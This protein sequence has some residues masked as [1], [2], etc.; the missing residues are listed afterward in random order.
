MVNQWPS[1]AQPMASQWPTNGQPM[2]SQWPTNGQ[3]MANQWP[4]SHWQPMA[5]QWPTNGQPVAIQWP[6]NVSYF[7]LL[8]LFFSNQLST[9]P[10]SRPPNVC[11]P[12]MRLQPTTV[13]ATQ[14]QATKAAKADQLINVHLDAAVENGG[15]PS[16]TAK[17]LISAT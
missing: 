10:M 15:Q 13:D 3:P 1:N 8:A 2:A 9:R 7:W 14:V 4:A 5:N 12:P 17:Y 6:A 11:S 16:L